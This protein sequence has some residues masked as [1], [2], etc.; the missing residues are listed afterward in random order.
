M[1]SIRPLG[2]ILAVVFAVSMGGLMWWM[3]KIPPH[4]PAPVAKASALW[5]KL[6]R[7]VYDK[8][9]LLIGYQQPAVF[10]G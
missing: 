3:L 10:R 7:Y 6:E 9:L 2:F 4:M 8:H 1:I 5:K